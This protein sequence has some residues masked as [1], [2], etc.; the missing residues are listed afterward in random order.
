MG[1]PLAGLWPGVG[2]L[3]GKMQSA[4]AA[5]RGLT[6]AVTETADR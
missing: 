4:I 5:E 1:A 2:L 3:L 6:P